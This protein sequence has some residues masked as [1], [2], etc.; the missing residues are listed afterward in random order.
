MNIP[1]D[2][3]EDPP[4]PSN[5][6]EISEKIQEHPD[7]PRKNSAF[8]MRESVELKEPNKPKQEARMAGKEITSPQTRQDRPNSPEETSSEKQEVRNLYL[9]L[10]HAYIITYICYMYITY[11]F[12]SRLLY[13][14]FPIYK[15]YIFFVMSEYF[16]VC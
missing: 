2:Q 8:N 10:L 16:C 9:W 4:T 3:K 12:L 1:Q 5:P 13:I 7:K 11:T 6:P 15:K 14:I